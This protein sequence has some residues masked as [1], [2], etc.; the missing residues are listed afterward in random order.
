MSRPYIQIYKRFNNIMDQALYV[1][2]KGKEIS[3]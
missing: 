1:I 3:S 2:V